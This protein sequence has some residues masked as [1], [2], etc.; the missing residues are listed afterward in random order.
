[1]YE[2]L[3]GLCVGQAAG[4]LAVIELCG[5]V[6]GLVTGRFS[7]LRGESVQRTPRGRN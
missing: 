1:L 4:W 3:C 7:F 5:G 2:W 6:T